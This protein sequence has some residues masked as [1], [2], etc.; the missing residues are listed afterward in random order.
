MFFFF[1]FQQSSGIDEKK[2][3]LIKNL[4]SSWDWFPPGINTAFA[5]LGKAG[6]A[7]GPEADYSAKKWDPWMLQRNLSWNRIRILFLH[8]IFYATLSGNF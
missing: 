7:E 1:L 4:T 8:R 2:E 3:D 5:E 6:V